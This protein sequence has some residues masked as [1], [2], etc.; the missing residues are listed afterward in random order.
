M[1]VKNSAYHEY[2]TE[3][4]LKARGYSSQ[5]H[6][7]KTFSQLAR[8]PSRTEQSLLNR[9]LMRA[10]ELIPINSR[11]SKLPWKFL[12]VSDQI[13]SGFPHTHQD[14]IVM[15]KSHITAGQ[16]HFD[17]LVDTLIHEKIH[18]Y[19]RFYPCE[20]NTLF[21][22]YWNLEIV[23][24]RSFDPQSNIRSNPDNNL[25]LYSDDSKPIMLEY[26][27]KK[28]FISLSTVMGDKRDHPHEMMAYVLTYILTRNTKPLPHYLVKYVQSAALWMQE[29]L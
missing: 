23:S 8:P 13:E 22:Q 16:K 17:N 26:D 2:L 14:V 9:A 1:N 29:Y 3:K 19:Q 21:L 6:A 10:N 25:L 18:V 12:V 5:L 15:P 20:T 24:R 7:V 4:D 27:D 28:D 11:L